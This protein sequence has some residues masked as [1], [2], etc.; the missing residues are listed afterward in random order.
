MV[1]PNE[2][3]WV[4]GAL[5]VIW[6]NIDEDEIRR[7]GGEM[8]TVAGQSEDAHS[9]TMVEIEKMLDINS[10]ESLEI[11]QAL[12]RKLS[13]QHLKDLGEALRVMAE[14]MDV[15][16][17][18]IEGMKVAAIAEFVAFAARTAA[19]AA[20]SI[21]TP[22]L[23]AGAEVVVVE[24]TRTVVEDIIKQAMQQIVAQIGQALYA[25]ILDTL[26]ASVGDLGEQ[27]LGDALG[28]TS[29]VS[30]SQVY[31][32]GRS[33]AGSSLTTLKGQLAHTA[34]DPLGRAG[35]LASGRGL[36]TGDN[37]TDTLTNINDT[38]TGHRP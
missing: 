25:P 32:A 17:D 14:G 15:A 35:D 11:F 9:T 37:G 6:P 36:L 28:V 2:L 18:L 19:V 8:R 12:W 20:E 23:G 34:D 4:L 27:L 3:T 5:G 29:G 38:V 33:E 31:D 7:L 24:T 26:V 21:M 13:G 30:L 10:S 22:G 1:L 16:A